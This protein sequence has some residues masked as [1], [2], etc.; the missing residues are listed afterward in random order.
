MTL[1]VG[2][3]GGKPCNCDL[4]QLLLYLS[5]SRRLLPLIK[6]SSLSSFIS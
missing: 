5:L 3:R 4:M 2:K 1:E 6:I